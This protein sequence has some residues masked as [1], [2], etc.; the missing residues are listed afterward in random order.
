MLGSK[1]THTINNIHIYDH[2]NDI[3]L[4]E[5]NM[6]KTWIKVYNELMF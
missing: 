2:N 5:K 3:Y 4:S 1:E 6:K